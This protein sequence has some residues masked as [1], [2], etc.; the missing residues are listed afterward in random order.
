MFK[1]KK[2]NYPFSVCKPFMDTRIGKTAEL[3]SFLWVYAV[4]YDI[5]FGIKACGDSRCPLLDV[6]MLQFSW[7]YFCIWFIWF[8][9]FK[10]GIRFFPDC[11]KKWWQHFFKLNNKIRCWDTS[12]ASYWTNLHIDNQFL[13]FYQGAGDINIKVLQ[14]VRHEHMKVT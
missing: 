13:L 10:C 4:I 3:F 14:I 9:F 12:W 8:C 11:K 5:W 2:E 6:C 1:G 7:Q